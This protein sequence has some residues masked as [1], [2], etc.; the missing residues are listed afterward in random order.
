[1]QAGALISIGILIFS[2]LLPGNYM[3]PTVSQLWNTNS[4]PW[5]QLQNT[6]NR[7]ISVTGGSN[8]AN[9]GNFR[10]SLALGGNPNLTNEVVMTVKVSDTKTGNQYL[11][12]LS[13]DSYDG[14]T[15]TDLPVD[16][17]TVKANATITYP[18]IAS[19]QVTQKI[20]I[21]N[22][23]GEQ[24]PY[25]LGASEIATINVPA[26]V[27]ENHQ[28]GIPIAWLGQNGYL[29]AGA[30]YTVSSYVSSADEPS[31][32]TIEMPQNAPKLFLQMRMCQSRYHTTVRK[33]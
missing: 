16:T 25:L 23:P 19:H 11:A 10:D 30:N 17:A 24:Y 27:Q 14:H 31:L 1:M 18:S 4:N 26:K 33:F 8:P 29:V 7:V 9:R 20:T 2:W 28:S 21:V 12:S 22:P 32:R 3:D 5:T 15:W 13:Y 6:W